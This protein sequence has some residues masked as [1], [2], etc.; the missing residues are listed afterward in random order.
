MWR[1][2]CY[3]VFSF[4]QRRCTSSFCLHRLQKDDV[5]PNRLTS[6]F[7]VKPFGIVFCHWEITKG[8]SSCTSSFLSD[9]GFIKKQLWHVTSKHMTST[10]FSIIVWIVFSLIKTKHAYKNI[11]PATLPTR[12]FWFCRDDGGR[13][14]LS[15]RMNHFIGNDVD[16][17]SFCKDDAG[18]WKLS[19]RM[20]HF[21]G[22]VADLIAF[23]C[24]CC[25]HLRFFLSKQDMRI[26]T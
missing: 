13:W 5:T 11:K 12:R 7:L 14:K 3:I 17:K 18:R 1:R 26:K 23:K 20:N 22:S 2:C 10:A 6:S 21:I 4:L 15:N 19:E 25:I 24:L 16:R 8:T 9:C